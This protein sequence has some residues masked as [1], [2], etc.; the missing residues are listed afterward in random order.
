M[1]WT[2]SP[3]RVRPSC[4]HNSLRF[5][6]AEKAGSIPAPRL[7]HS[8]STARLS[9]L[10]RHRTDFARRERT[11]PSAARTPLR[12]RLATIRRLRL[13][14]TNPACCSSLPLTKRT[15][16]PVAGSPLEYNSQKPAA[17]LAP[18]AGRIERECHVLH[19]R[20]GRPG[21][22]RRAGRPDRSSPMRSVRPTRSAHAMAPCFLHTGV[23]FGCPC[24]ASCRAG[25]RTQPARVASPGHRKPAQSDG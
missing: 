4:G 16:G 7:L 12:P 6:A 15:W 19:V 10:R 1:L 11:P 9:R 20:L 2:L 8:R 22:T 3:G 25:A 14:H 24:R 23:L 17:G 13:W 21:A 18:R 5:R